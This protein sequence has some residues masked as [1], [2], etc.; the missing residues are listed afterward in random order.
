[1]KKS[2]V[3]ALA[4][5]GLAAVGVQPAK[6]LFPPTACSPGA[7]FV[8]AAA[9]ASSSWSGTENQYV[10]NIDVWNLFDGTAANGVSNVITWFGLGST[11]FN[12]TATL[13]DATYGGN[14]VSWVQA[15]NWN[16][17]IVGVQIDYA[18]AGTNGLNH[19]L[20]GCDVAI[21]QDELQT[22]YSQTDKAL[23][24][25]FGTGDALFLIDA[26]ANYGWHAQA[27]NGTTCSIWANSNGQGT[28]LVNADG[29]AC[30]NVVPEP[31]S[32]ALLGTG[33]IGLGGVG[34]VRSRRKNA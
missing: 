17:N 8:C 32:M 27:V 13:L 34:L 31:V 4:G 21:H 7:L 33:L 5:L 25:V 16:N 10:V 28:G 15:S 22:C 1:M 18:A 23:H 26:D 30:G 2:V 11:T 14:A 12:G 24:L 3:V 6:A 29:S 19:G 20:I 9:S